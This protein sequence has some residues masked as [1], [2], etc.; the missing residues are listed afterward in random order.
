MALQTDLYDSPNPRLAAA[1]GVGSGLS[2]CGICVLLVTQ[3]RYRL[4]TEYL[5]RPTGTVSTPAARR[6]PNI[7]GN[8]K[9]NNCG[10][11]TL[12]IKR[13]T[14]IVTTASCTGNDELTR[15]LARCKS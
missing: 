6:N 12:A 1:D 8:W 7:T 11:A 14:E 9:F 4:Y 5:I 13:L 3:A 10:V 15:V 2:S